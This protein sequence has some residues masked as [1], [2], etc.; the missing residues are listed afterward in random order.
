VSV[1]VTIVGGRHYV[2][3]LG[4]LSVGSCVI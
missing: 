1:V 3:S 4:F 2:V